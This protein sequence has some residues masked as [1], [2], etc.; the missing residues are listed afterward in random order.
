MLPTSLRSMYAPL[1]APPRAERPLHVVLACSGSVAS[2]KV[3]LMAA[4][5]LEVR[6]L[7]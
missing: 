5:L 1:S 2:V 7:S 6:R 3:P 4:R